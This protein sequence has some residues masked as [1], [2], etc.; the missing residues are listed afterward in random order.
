M[1]TTTRT[2]TGPATH[3]SGTPVP[4]PRPAVL[5]DAHVGDIKGAFGTIRLDDAAPRQGLSARL[6]TLLAIVGPGLIVMVGDNDAGAFSTY[7]QAGQNYGTQLLWTLLMLVPV[8]Y[9]NQEMVLRLGAVTGVGH[10]RLILERFGRFWGAFS[11]IDLFLLNA[12]TLV[13]EFIGVTLAAGYLGLPKAAAVV[14]AAAV[15]IA[16]AFTGSFRRFERVAVTLCVGSLLL[17]PIYF[18]VHPRTSQMAH[19]FVTPAVP[20]GAGQLAAV[21]LVIISIVGTTVAPW[22]LFFQQSYVIDKRITPRFMRYEKADLWIGIV[23]VIVGAAAMMGIT[24][25]AFAGTDGFGQFSD[26]AAVARGIEAKAGHLAGVLFAIAL[27]DASVIGA[28]A[29]S[30]STA[31][32]IG[33]VFGIKHSLHRGVKGAKGFYGIYA[34]LVVTAAAITLLST[35]HTQGLMTQF[36]QVLAGVLLPSATVFLLL[37]CN[38][39]A[40]LGPWVNGPRTNAFTSAVVGVLV[41]LSMILTAAVV[42]PGIS[43]G[44]ILWIMTGCGVAGVLVAGYSFTAGR[45]ATKEDPVDRTDRENWRMPPLETLDKPVMSTARKVGMGALRAYLLV[46]MAMVIVKIIQTALSH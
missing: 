46:A 28:F 35:D 23:I 1:T 38:D 27:L 21:M 31:Y 43:S 42:W 15:I 44:A 25:A 37:L 6:K 16:S 18:L 32:A 13:T 5:D 45:T 22:Q 9:V 7:G 3:D 34:G 11:V 40:V 26:A 30:L 17:V 19:D 39:R 29:V 2:T 36:V 24:A 12:L 33:D 20:G 10:A 8:L 4:A 14:L 41:T